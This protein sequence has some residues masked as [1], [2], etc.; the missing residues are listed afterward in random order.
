MGYHLFSKQPNR[1]RCEF[2]KAN[3]YPKNNYPMDEKDLTPTPEELTAE[4]EALSEVQEEEVREKLAGE[5]GIE[6]DNPLLDTLVTREIEQRKKLSTAIGQ[7]IKY[8]TAA[9]G[10][11]PPTEV[12]P[13]PEDGKTLTAEEITA[14]VKA[15]FE[16]RDLDEMD[17]SD[18]IKAQIKSL[19]QVRNISVRQAAK[20]PYIVHLVETDQATRKSDDATITRTPK[21]QKVSFDK[22]KPPKVDMST[23]EGRK[24]WDEYTKFLKEG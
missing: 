19:A 9:Q 24:T 17:H 14:K 2:Y 4:Q 23:A 22:A 13:K 15:E 18:D 8:R 20:D 3:G 16:Q 5:L 6:A 10:V 1:L 12:K 7:K 11:K 21:G